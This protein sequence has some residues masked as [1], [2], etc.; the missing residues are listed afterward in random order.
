M[1]A[2][3]DV[4]KSSVNPFEDFSV[5]I[6]IPIVNKSITFKTHQ[7]QTNKTQKKKYQFGCSVFEDGAIRKTPH[8]GNNY[9]YITYND[10]YCVCA[11]ARACV[12][13]KQLVMYMPGIFICTIPTAKE[14][15]FSRTFPGQNYHFSGQSIEELEVINQV[16]PKKRIIFIDCMIDY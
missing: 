11:R 6:N 2:V 4:R 8:T 7:L 14:I 13:L 10:Y 12:L 16:S 15:L 9:L 1:I 5:L 3:P